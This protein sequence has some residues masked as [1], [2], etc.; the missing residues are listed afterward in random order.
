MV[1]RDDV[2]TAL[3]DDPGHIHELTGL[4][5]QFD[6]QVGGSAGLHQA[7]V[8]DPG[9][10]GHVDVAAGDQADHLLAL[11][12]KLVEHGGS[13]R[14]RPRALG[15]HL[16]LFNQGED[17]RG[18]F[19]LG[20]ESNVVHVI[21]HH[22]IGDFPGLLYG[23]AVGNGGDAGQGLHLA[24]VHGVEH[25]G[26]PRRLYAIDLDVGG[27]G[28]DGAG[29]AGDQS[30]A[31]DGHDHRVHVAHF[32][33]DF[34]TDGALAGD[35]VLVVKGVDEG[36]ALLLFQLQGLV[37]GVV[38]HAGDEAD[39]R[40]VALGGLHL[41]DGG[42]VRQAD[43]GGNAAL[44]GSQRHALGVVAGGAGDDALSLFLI[45]EHGDFVAGAAKLK[46]TG[47]LQALGL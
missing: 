23:D 6:Q 17:C 12:G 2:A 3:G 42:G 20:D 13:H 10:A 46:G 16:L 22:F 15:D 19:V 36:V 37:V 31:A 24:V 8:N 14:N 29:H 4:V 28:L 9:Q 27:D 43:Q 7:P 26:G 11:N 33:H 44:A 1:N 18:D 40:A 39:L 47:L 32:V 21:F 5:H 34:Q 38:I 30:A 35:D 45:G 41:G 25:T